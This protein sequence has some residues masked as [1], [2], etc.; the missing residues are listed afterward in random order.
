MKKVVFYFS[1]FTCIYLTP[2]QARIWN[3]SDFSAAIDKIAG[4]LSVSQLPASAASEMVLPPSVYFT[5]GHFF[6]ISYVSLLF[7]LLHRESVIK[8]WLKYTVVTVL[9]VGLLADVYIY[10]IS[11][12]YPSYRHEVF[13]FIELPALVLLLVG[14]GL[15]LFQWGAKLG[16]RILKWAAL[17]LLPLAGLLVV[18]I[19]YIPHAPMLAILLSLIPFIHTKSHHY[20]ID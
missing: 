15:V 20:E 11:E 19:Q 18:A 13:L 9:L 16:K 12:C 4:L 3:G 6:V 7:I 1:L 14:F 17:A 2:I 10:W 5:Y 8:K